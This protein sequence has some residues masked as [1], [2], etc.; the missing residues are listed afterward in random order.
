MSYDIETQL[1]NE[2]PQTASRLTALVA[3]VWSLS[4][5]FI[6]S[7]VKAAGVPALTR[8]DDRRKTARSAH[9]IRESLAHMWD[10]MEI[11]TAPHSWGFLPASLIG[12]E[13][14]KPIGSRLQ[15][16]DID[17]ALRTYALNPKGVG[18]SINVLQSG[19]VKHLV[20]WAA[21]W[22]KWIRAVFAAGGHNPRSK[23][24]ADEAKKNSKGGV[25]DGLRFYCN[26]CNSWKDNDGDVTSDFGPECRGCGDVTVRAER[27]GEQSDRYEAKVRIP[28]IHDKH[29]S[30]N[31]VTLKGNSNDSGD[32]IAENPYDNSRSRPNYNV[33]RLAR[34]L[35]L[36]SGRF[37]HR[38]MATVMTQNE[39][40]THESRWFV[41]VAVPCSSDGDIKDKQALKL[42][43]LTVP[44]CNEM[45]RTHN[46]LQHRHAIINADW[47][48]ITGAKPADRKALKAIKL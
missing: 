34:K 30:M 29:W 40:Y 10:I 26:R 28:V 35:G 6:Q 48:G 5:G 36:G 38:I 46:Q 24:T 43:K 23:R 25:H 2:N 1:E 31:S 18:Y 27:I 16:A 15:N 32:I 22:P 14:V 13:K 19:K 8:Y 21:V 3:V 41:W 33:G 9:A 20:K 44:E 37:H 42:S 45:I 17:V 39:G 12:H 11:N 7:V 4:F 47:N